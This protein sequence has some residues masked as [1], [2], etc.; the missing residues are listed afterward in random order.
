MSPRA[1]FLGLLWLAACAEPWAPPGLAP[2]QAR[3]DDHPRHRLFDAT[4][5]WLPLGGELVS[6]LCRFDTGRPLTVRLPADAGR[7]DPPGG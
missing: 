3:L 7:D 2:Y 4:P 1:A 5:Y 6:F